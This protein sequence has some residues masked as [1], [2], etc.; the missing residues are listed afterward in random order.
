MKKGYIYITLTAILF[1][2]ME[3]ALKLVNQ[4][5]NPIQLTFLRFFIGSLLLFPFA[6]RRLKTKNIRLTVSDFRFF[7][8]TG[9][10]C[11][12]ISMILYQLALLYASA[13]IIAVLLSSITVFSVIFAF[14]FLD[15]KLHP[16]R[17]ISI[18]INVIGVVII[19][20][21]GNV[22][23]SMEGIILVLL[24]SAA[25]AAYTVIGRKRIQYY[26][27]ISLTCFSF[28]FGS[29]EILL[30]ILI[31][32]T[33]PVAN[34]FLHNGM[35]LFANIPLLQG[36][37]L[38][39]APSLIFI[40]V[41]VTGLGYMFYFL[42]IEATSTASGSI[43]FFIKPALAPILA[44][45]ILKEPVTINMAMGILI[46]ILGSAIAFTGDER[47]RKIQHLQNS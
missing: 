47:I 18:I 17:L 42:G 40:G 43:V 20:N 41:F 7:A 24:S 15:E 26:G 6:V 23:G 13:S 32:R 46:I 22:T 35:A 1:S 21:P 5:F 31:T 4:D 25:F 11:V 28:L 16:Y 19:I 27:G 29:I 45:F 37:N 39:T 2:S 36:I 12:V 44:L 34:F 30:L 8:L 3:I 38:Q 9:F 33:Y 14:L 10:I